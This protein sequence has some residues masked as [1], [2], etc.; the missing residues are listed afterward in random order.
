M[1]NMGE[2]QGSSDAPSMPSRCQLASACG[3]HSHM[4]GDLLASPMGV[5]APFNQRLR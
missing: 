4:E 5:M 1:H 3:H 2:S